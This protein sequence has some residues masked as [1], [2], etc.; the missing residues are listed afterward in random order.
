[1]MI[2]NPTVL[3]IDDLKDNIQVLRALVLEQYKDAVVV[4]ALNGRLGIELAKSTHPDLILLDILMPEMDGFQVCKQIKDDEGLSGIPVVFV[5]ALKEDK[6]NRMKAVE[7]GADGFLTKPIDSTYLKVMLKAMFKIREAEIFKQNENERLRLL[8]KEKTR[9]LEKEL[10]KEERL[11]KRLADSEDRYIKMIGNLESGI[12]IHTPD[13]KIIDCN[14]KAQEILELSRQQMLGKEAIDSYWAFVDEN[15]NVLPLDEY[16]VVKILDTKSSLKDYVV[17]VRTRERGIVWVSVNGIIRYHSDQSIREIVI[18]FIDISDAV[19][20]EK[21]LLYAANNDFLTGLNNR[22]FYEREL[23]ALN[24][25]DLTPV[26]VAMADINGLKLIN[27]A[28][29]HTYGDDMLR[30]AS[31]VIRNA[32]D[33][34]DI[35]CRIGGDEFAIIMPHTTS[36]EANKKIEKIHQLAKQVAIQSI[37]LS[38]SVG[39]ATKTTVLEDLFDIARAAEDIMYRQKLIAIPSMRSNAIETI[40]SA[41]YEKDIYSEYHSRRVS[42]IAARLGEEIGLDMQSIREIETCGLVHDIGKI[43]IPTVILNKKGPLTTEEREVINTHPEIGFRIL[44]SS[45]QLRSISNIVLNHHERWDGSGYPRK[46]KGDDIPLQARVIS[47]ADAFEAMTSVRPYRGKKTYEEAKNELHK[48]AGT[49]FDP[50]LVEVFLLNF[51]TIIED[52]EASLE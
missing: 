44:N 15:L 35:V 11:T 23:R 8:V 51:D 4:S 26:S 25:E 10:A 32:V 45:T 3:I 18:S 5:T 14:L 2:E 40:I 52:A 22:R 47:V 49:Q 6:K 12:V 28:F 9:K 41:L 1:M 38:I 39:Y 33:T 21:Q 42:K 43:I 37:E 20:K 13:T 50:D 29:G 24:E 31:E 48:M 16:P 30:R 27:D 36:E 17:G 34:E 19:V 46:I 7:V